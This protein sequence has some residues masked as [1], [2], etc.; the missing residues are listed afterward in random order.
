MDKGSSKYEGSSKGSSLY[1]L[2]PNILKKIEH[3]CVGFG[4]VEGF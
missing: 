2:V 3:V 4:W 1:E